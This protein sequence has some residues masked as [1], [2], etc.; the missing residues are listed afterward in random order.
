M[1]CKVSDFELENFWFLPNFLRP[2]TFAHLLKVRDF[3]EQVLDTFFV[4]FY[5]TKNTQTDGF[6]NYTQ[7]VP[8]IIKISLQFE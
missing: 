7:R 4:P 1:L 8:A 6:S 5:Y 3:M 2:K